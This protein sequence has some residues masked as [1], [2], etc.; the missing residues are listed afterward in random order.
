[1][2]G[3]RRK[4]GATRRAGG[5]RT[6]PGVW[7][8]RWCLAISAV[9]L[10]WPVDCGE[11]PKA[12]GH[13]TQSRARFRCSRCQKHRSHSD[14]R[15]FLLGRS[16]QQAQRRRGG[17]WCATFTAYAIALL[18][19]TG[20]SPSVRGFP[21][22]SIARWPYPEWFPPLDPVAVPRVPA[23]LPLEIRPSSAPR[24]CHTLRNASIGSRDGPGPAILIGVLRTSR[25]PGSSSRSIRQC[26]PSSRVALRCQGLRCGR[27][28]R[29]R[30]G[31][32]LAS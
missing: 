13:R 1:M 19:V 8:Y 5:R 21:R 22:Q 6:W 15:P 9:M 27:S 24:R 26:A 20:H 10:L 25:R 30:T 14:D 17:F 28:W 4:N 18:V 3:G 12:T 32:K 29:R 16:V 23:A 7:R 11:S 31:A 2:T